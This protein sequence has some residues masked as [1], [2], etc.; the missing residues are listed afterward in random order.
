MFLQTGRRHQT[1][2][3][4][5]FLL[6]TIQIS[7]MEGADKSDADKNDKNALKNFAELP[8]RAQNLITRYVF[9]DIFKEETMI[10]SLSLAS[11]GI[12][13][14]GTESDPEEEILNKVQKAR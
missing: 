8:Q 9:T 3:L 14:S 1:K 7:A 13:V 6:F 12:D 10:E 5:T 11:E 4:F 2:L